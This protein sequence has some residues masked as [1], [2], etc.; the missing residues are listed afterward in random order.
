MEW[1]DDKILQL[2]KFYEENECLYNVILS[3]YHNRNK[4]KT[5]IA[6]IAQKLNTTGMTSENVLLM[7]A[8]TFAHHWFY[9]NNNNVIQISIP[10]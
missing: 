7:H 10:P 9:Y 1:S 8:P 3:T 4:K 5:V 2:I 6:D